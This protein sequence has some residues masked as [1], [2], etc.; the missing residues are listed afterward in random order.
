ML[1]DISVSWWAITPVAAAMGIGVLLFSREVGRVR[2]E[3]FRRGTP[4]P[5]LVGMTGMVSAALSP[6]GKVRVRGETWN[7]RALDGSH[8][9][10]GAS[11][12]VRG[13]HG[14]LLEVERTEATEAEG[15]KEE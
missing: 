14:A 4:E 7:A 2:R 11:V 13:E 15:T 5:I 3:Q 12:I 9:Q 10:R 1:P 8:I 6:E